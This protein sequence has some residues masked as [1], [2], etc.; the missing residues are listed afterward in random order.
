MS[1]LR[2][3]LRRG[4]RAAGPV[5]WLL[6]LSVLTG[7]AAVVSRQKPPAFS[8]HDKAFYLSAQDVDFVR[9]GLNVT[10]ES[11]SI[12]AG[13]V[14][15]VR[16]KL[17]DPKGLPLDR[18]GVVTPGAVSISFIAATIPAGASQYTAYT[19]RQQTSPITKQTATQ[20]GTDSGGSYQQ[21]ADGEYTYTFKTL[22][23][24]GYNR[25]AVHTIGFYSSRD[26][27]EF[28]LGTQYDDGVFHF[29]PDGSATPPAFPRDVVQTASCNRCHDP[30]S[31][32]GGARRSVE[33]CVLC[34]QPQ[35]TDPDTGNKVDFKVMIH[36]IHMGSSLPSVQAGKPYQI[37]GFNQSVNDWSTVV[38]PADVRRCEVC[39]AQGP[40]G[41]PPRTA[42]QA[43]YY[44]TKPT[45][46]A[47]GACHDNVNFDTGEN[48]SADNLPEISD[49]LCANC[50]IP[51]GEIEFDASIKG[52]HTIPNHSTM[53]PGVVF[54]ITKV[55]NSAPGQNP[56]VTFS[57]KDNTGNPILPSDMNF[58]NL[59]T[60][61]S[62]TYDYAGYVSESALKATGSNGVYTYTFKWAVPSDA[63]GTF[64]MG[65]EG[66]RNV[67]LFPGKKIEMPNIRDVGF[68]KVFYYAVTDPTPVPRRTVVAEANCNSCHESL[69][70]HG[71]IRRNVEYCVICHNPNNTD[72]DQR[73]AAQS[74]PE[75]I[76]FKTMI[77][78]IHTGENLTTDLTIYGFG[79]SVH[80]FSSAFAK[81]SFTASGVRFPGDRRDCAQC[82][83]NSSEQ[84]PLRDGLLP[85]LQ[86]RGWYSPQL[87]TAAACLACHTEKAPAAHALAQTSQQL[88]ESCEVC[89]G[90]DA[91][92]AIDKVHAR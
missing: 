25:S 39:H 61:T 38:F 89:H 40:V 49:N 2:E 1:Q 48:H 84:L 44:L 50:H 36:K 15:Q 67:T 71:G 16:F 72:A 17:A 81:T 58:L 60:S 33:L 43:N 8:V 35:T 52:A 13:G 5:S 59:V 26:L 19:T 86:P 87:P 90:P 46:A 76:H 20:A 4:V 23:P 29:V 73:P 14:I 74:P 53:L 83:A 88:G 79:G 11:A 77:H 32:H 12:D 82:H 51:Q 21:V 56:T 45:R 80:N 34:H 22:A 64:A 66:Y 85:S 57:I 31:A 91:D 9:P 69:E 6:A 75:S 28:N 24:A 54:D 30:L 3:N 42:A 62:S 92:F 65:I 47:C 37:I 70:L 63:Q 18:L 7:L 27:S 41:N 68:N 55:D 78:K 10:I